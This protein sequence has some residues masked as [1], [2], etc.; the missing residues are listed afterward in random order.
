MQPHWFPVHDFLPQR[1]AVTDGSCE[2]LSR[3]KVRVAM[4]KELFFMH[5]FVFYYS[6][7][8]AEVGGK[9]QL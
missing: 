4:A 7:L 9:V 5:A 6:E 1:D 2:V 3:A 8:V